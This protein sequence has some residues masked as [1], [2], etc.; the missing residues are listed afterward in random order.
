[1]TQTISLPFSR[2]DREALAACEGLRAELVEQL[3]RGAADVLSLALHL[4]RLL[5]LHRGSSSALTQ[6]QD[7]CAQGTHAVRAALLEGFA[8]GRE[9]LTRR[10]T[11]AR[12]REPITRVDDETYAVFCAYEPDDDIDFSEWADSV[13]RDLRKR[14]ARYVVVSG[15]ESSAAK[16]REAA[17]LVGIE[18]PPP[19]HRPVT[20]S[21]G[22]AGPG[23][24]RFWPF[25]G[26]GRTE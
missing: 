5:A 18:P 26:G 8:R 21:S 17:A 20:P 3:E 7:E 16:V 2:E 24:R 19:R 25:R 14:G 6:L 4:G 9:E 1:M 13:V 15:A 12:M 22:A 10:E 11:L 23:W